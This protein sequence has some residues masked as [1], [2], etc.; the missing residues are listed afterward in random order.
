[1]NLF[2]L[3]PNKKLS[4]IY[5][6]DRHIVKMPTETA[7]MLSFAYHNDM[8]WGKDIPP[9]VMAFS[10]THN[11]HPC[12]KWIQESLSNWL[13]TAKFGMELYQEYQHRFKKPDKHTRAKSIFEF[14][15]NNPPKI[16]DIG[17]TKF[18]E[19]MPEDCKIYDCPIE[20]YRN[21]YKVAK[22]HLYK[23]TNRDKPDWI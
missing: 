12:S 4:A 1:M 21:Y 6:T 14:A 20:N 23:W 2:I 7:Q 5:H 16:K 18:A 15:L 10:K 22:A 13:W 11:L 9:F 3:S 8:F 17:L 19:A